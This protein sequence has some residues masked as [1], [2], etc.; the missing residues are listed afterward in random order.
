MLGSG[1]M[2]VQVD[3]TSVTNTLKQVHQ[4]KIMNGDA[5]ELGYHQLKGGRSEII[6]NAAGCYY[7]HIAIEHKGFH[8]CKADKLAEPNDYIYRVGHEV[9]KISKYVLLSSDIHWQHVSDGVS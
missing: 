8:A 2:L 4:L 9:P 1:S 3:Q 7:R 5:F 6:G